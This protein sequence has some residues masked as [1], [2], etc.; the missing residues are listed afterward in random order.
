METDVN[1]QERTVT[2]HG[3]PGMKANMRGQARQIY[4]R[5]YY[6]NILKQKNVQLQNEITKLREEVES[7]KKDNQLYVT[8][9]RQFDE[10]IKEVRQL[11]GEL[12]DYNLALDKQRSDTKPEDIMAILYHIQAQNDK[13][14]RQLDDIFIQRKNKETDIAQIEDQIHDI[15]ASFEE[16]LNELDP[17]LRSQYESLREENGQLEQ[18]IMKRRN[19]L[20]DVSMK[21][22]IAESKLREDPTKER[23]QQLRD[24]KSKLQGKK[25]DLQLQTDEMNLPFPEARERLIS[26]AKDDQAQLKSIEQRIQE[27]KK[28]TE[29]YQRQ[30]KEIENELKGNQAETTDKNKYEILM[31]RDK[32][33]T[34][35][36]NNFDSIKNQELEQVIVLEKS[37]QNILETMSKNII[38]MEK[39]PTKDVAKVEE[40]DIS[41]K[42]RMLDNEMN[43]YELLKHEVDERVNQLKR[44]ENIEENIEKNKKIVKDKMENM[45]MELDTKYCNLD[46]L[47]T[48]AEAEKKK[49]VILRAYYSAHKDALKEH[50]TLSAMKVDKKRIQLLDN[51]TYK[52]LGELEKRVSST[53][54]SLFNIKQF[55]EGKKYEANYASTLAECLSLISAINNEN[56]KVASGMH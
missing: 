14:R 5:S 12:A 55:I 22:S 13:Q 34:E 20:D 51:D 44:M 40:D 18:E 32:E 47:G 7:I 35:F 53:E 4:D 9:E 45:Q 2:H 11:E 29:S 46:Q 37:I 49:L 26:K 16:R 52:S 17:D 8:L 1:I 19:D 24:E 25:D 28:L 43:T 50:V 33:Y 56:V 38:K 10:L 54:G 21:L 30:L 31:E 15:N 23:A 48:K 3:I 27:I 6:L 42:K 36:I 41:Y 39:P